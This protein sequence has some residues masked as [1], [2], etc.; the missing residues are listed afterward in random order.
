MLKKNVLSQ[1]IS[2][3]SPSL[4]LEITAKAKNL[5]A[6]G[7]DVVSFAAGE[8]DFDTPEHIKKAAVQ[9]INEGFTKYTPS[10]GISEL[11]EKICDNL[12]EKKNIK[13]HPEEILIGCGA[14]HCLYN[15]FQ[16]LCSP[17]DEVIISAPYWVSYPEMV[18]LSSAVP[19][20]VKTEFQDGF[21]VSGCR[22]EKAVSPNTRAFII[23]SPSNPTGSIYSDKELKD[24]A[25][26]LKKHNI[27]TISDEIYDELS[28]DGKANSII[29][30]DE[31]IKDNSVLISGVS[32]TYAMTGW[33]IGFMAGPKEIIKAVGNLQSHSTSNP[34]SI[35]QKA[36]LAA[37]SSSRQTIDE[38][39][40][41]FKE[42]RKK[43]FEGLKQINRLKPFYPKGGFYV[44]CDISG[45][46]NDSL[47]FSKKLLE[48]ENV[49]VIPGIAFGY[50]GYIRLSFATSIQQIEKGVARIKHWIE[51]NF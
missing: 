1:K 36:A 31:K 17:K 28:Y 5:K 11:K 23:N 42:R 16:A 15:I 48:D 4:T 40:S 9:A 7:K 22:L 33:R 24:L 50:E 43:I 39:I 32:K 37:F 49:A 18:K 34:C 19:V 45:V 29:S 2:R 51:N 10:S 14:K 21:K 13:Y 46:T 27:F 3:I 25:G 8:P 41:V 20:V 44:F 30:L 26:V 6:Q 47:E 38:M 35:S 12:L